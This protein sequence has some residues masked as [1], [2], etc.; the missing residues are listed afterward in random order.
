[1]KAPLFFLI[2]VSFAQWVVADEMSPYLFYQFEDA[3]VFPIGP[4]V[5]NA[6]GLQMMTPESIVI[7]EPGIVPSRFLEVSGS[8]VVIGNRFTGHGKTH[9]EIWVR[10]RAVSFKDGAEFFDFDGAAVA[11]FQNVDGLAELHALHIGEDQKGFW[12]STGV[13]LRVKDGVVEDWF[14][15]NITQQWEVGTWDLAVNGTQV[16]QGIGRG[17]CAD[18]KMFEVWLYG[19]GSQSVNRFDDLLISAD[20]PDVLE[21]KIA[22]MRKPRISTSSVVSSQEKK[23]SRQTSDDKRRQHMLPSPDPKKYGQVQVLNMSLK[24]V[25]GGRHIGEFESKDKNGQEQ[26]IAL[27]SPGYDEDGKAKPL[28]VRIRC[29]A[30]LGEGVS[31]SQIEWAITEDPKEGANEVKVIVFGTF[32]TGPSLIASVP[33]EWSNKALS[34]HCG[35]LGLTKR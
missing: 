20:P 22:S 31:L 9:L 14:R 5:D 3:K 1:M 27:Y 29:D 7:E 18:G 6:Q 19:N 4:L 24:V 8:T 17:A 28:Q 13:R 10:P 32:A 16:L 15:I 26:K 33:S 12:V 25:G 35:Q 23:V 30:K 11:L 21:S 34:I 2:G